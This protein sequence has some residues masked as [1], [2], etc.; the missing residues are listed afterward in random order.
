[1]LFS[2]Y[3][4]IIIFGS[5]LTKKFNNWGLKLNID[6]TCRRSIQYGLKVKYRR[7]QQLGVVGIIEPSSLPLNLGTNGFLEHLSGL[8]K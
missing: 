3:I 5:K 8:S 7:T 1:M 4:K 2:K 6:L